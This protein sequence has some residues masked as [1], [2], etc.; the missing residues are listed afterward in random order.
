MILL[1]WIAGAGAKV[2]WDMGW[3]QTIYDLLKDPGFLRI[4]NS[5]WDTTQ[6]V[7]IPN[8]HTAGHAPRPMS[9]I[10]VSSSSTSICNSS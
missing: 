4:I 2:R 9:A 10:T 3:A 6:L 7:K 1:D 8:N 5:G